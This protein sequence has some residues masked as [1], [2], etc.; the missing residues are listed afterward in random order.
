MFASLFS[1]HGSVYVRIRTTVLEKGAKESDDPQST[2]RTGGSSDGGG[3]S[4]VFDAAILAACRSGLKLFGLVADN[5]AWTRVCWTPSGRNIRGCWGWARCCSWAVAK[6][7]GAGSVLAREA[8]DALCSAVLRGTLLVVLM[9]ED[10][11]QRKEGERRSKET[12]R[13]ERAARQWRT[14]KRSLVTPCIA[15]TNRSDDQRT[16]RRVDGLS[17]SRPYHEPVETKPGPR[18][19]RALEERSRH[20]QAV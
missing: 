10:R 1:A 4:R 14:A 7:F 15:R 12:N 13:T 18:R 11:R 16:N 2:P 20:A 5:R 8:S 6:E 9:G 19:R 3:F 17:C